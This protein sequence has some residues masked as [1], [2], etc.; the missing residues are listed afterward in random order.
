M[1]PRVAPPR[2]YAADGY[3]PRPTAERKGI[4]LC[5]SGGGYRATLFHLG[6]LRRLD[7]LGILPQIDTITSV[8]GGSITAAH[9]AARMP[10]PLNGRVPN[11][12][13]T[14]ARP[15]R[16]FTGKNIR[17]GPILKRLLIW[18]WFRSGTSVEALADAYE[19]NLTPMKLKDL[20][21]RPDF[22]LCATDMAFGDC[23]RF[24]RTSI[25]AYE[26]G[27]IIPTPADWPLGKAVAASSC[28]PPI[29]GPMRMPFRAS[30]Y[31]KGKAAPG[32]ARDAAIADLRLTDGGDYDN[33]GLEPV[34]KDHAVVLVSD[35]GGTFDFQGDRNLFWR[36]GRYT[37][38]IENQAIA[39]RKR[40][41]ISNFNAG[42]MHGA[43][44]GIGSARS[45]YNTGD[46]QGYSLDLA[47]NVIG[48]IRTD[49]DA[50][51][52]A[53][54]SVLENHGYFL[55]DAAVRK[56]LSELVPTPAPALVPPRP[57]WMVSED[58]IR[59]A[60][61]DSGERRILGRS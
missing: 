22:I 3:L 60:L 8:S 30:A 34:W 27:Y 16:E 33:L 48:E 17:T 31:A 2:E 38:I 49:L 14:V 58:R 44:W 40:W 20:P 28:F 24:T 13:E 35:G 6:A 46:T 9:L 53:E 11:W 32:P 36:I 4:G 26:P 12:E 56:H 1:I 52:D 47:Q 29:F 37:A 45:R 43:Y 19:K 5:L 25:G 61:A 55:A 51:S 42:V 7:E 50:F 59:Q 23:W 21:D 10:R 39:L 18:N 54:A 57:G 41:L 15:L